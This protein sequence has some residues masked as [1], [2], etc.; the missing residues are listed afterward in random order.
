MASPDGHCGG[1]DAREAVD[2]ALMRNRLARHALDGGRTDR[3]V[4]EVIL[5]EV[6]YCEAR[7]LQQDT[8]PAWRAEVEKRLSA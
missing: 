1:F 3:E 2:V 5:S 7:G 6:E 4:L 8:T